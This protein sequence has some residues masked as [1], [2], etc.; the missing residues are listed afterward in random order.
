[1]SFA[2]ALTDTVTRSAACRHAGEVV[3]GLD[4]CCRG[5]DRSDGC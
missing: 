1:M 5:D 4:A 3:A 2:G